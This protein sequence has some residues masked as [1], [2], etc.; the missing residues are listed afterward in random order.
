M[1]KIK[2]AALHRRPRQQIKST[3]YQRVLQ[4]IQK[5]IHL[6]EPFFYCLM[7]LMGGQ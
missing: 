2:K 1:Q 6:H 3:H 4:I 7:R 5:F